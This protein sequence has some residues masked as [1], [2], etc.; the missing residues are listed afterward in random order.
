MAGIC[1]LHFCEYICACLY[2]H[3]SVCSHRRAVLLDCRVLRSVV[4]VLTFAR[5]T[6]MPILCLLVPLENS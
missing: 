3:N 1:L 2:A 6:S 5:H 4:G